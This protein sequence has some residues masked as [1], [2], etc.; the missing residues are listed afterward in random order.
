M[1]RLYLYS[2]INPA[3]TGTANYFRLFYSQIPDEVFKNNEIFVVIDRKFYSH[4]IFDNSEY[5]IVDFRDVKKNTDDI[6]VYFLA[7]NEFHRYSHKALYDHKDTDG[8]SVSVV[9]EPCMWMNIQ[10][11]CSMREYGFK[12]EDLPYFAEYQYGED[13]AF[14]C[15]QNLVRK[16][17][18]IFDYTSLAATHI[19]ENSDVVVFH[20]YYAK[21]K[22]LLEKSPTYTF[23][24]EQDLIVMEHPH[25]DAAKNVSTKVSK[26]KYVVGTFGWVKK[27]KQVEDLLLAYNEFYLKLSEQ[28][29]NNVE[30]RIVGETEVTRNF[31]P[32]GLAETLECKDTIKFYGYVSNVE[33]DE[34]LAGTSIIF[35][36]RFPSCGESSG[37]VYKTKSLGIPIALSNY[38]AFAEEDADYFISVNMQT[39]RTEIRDVIAKE[40]DIFTKNANRNKKKFNKEQNAYGGVESTLKKIIAYQNGTIQ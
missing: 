33:M 6:S 7:N 1:A 26:D 2:P 5:N 11:M 37:P 10:A 18:E 29:K 14:F 25:D 17:S 19:Y 31:N 12:E 15:K 21:N 38:G 28:D 3:K 30:L 24:K 8:L 40:Y 20:S 16:T 9:H 32:V 27:V 35:S 4:N 13:A 23:K 22:Y 36:L 39:Q 34:L